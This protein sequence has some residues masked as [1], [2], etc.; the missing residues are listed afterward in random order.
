MAR[1]GHYIPAHFYNDAIP[2]FLRDKTRMTALLITRDGIDRCSGGDLPTGRDGLEVHIQAGSL[3]YPDGIVDRLRQE[4][5]DAFVV[6]FADEDDLDEAATLLRRLRQELPEA[7]LALMV[8][9]A[10]TF[11]AAKQLRKVLDGVRDL[12]LVITGF[13]GGR[14]PMRKVLEHVLWSWPH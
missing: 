3:A 5:M 2:E 7:T 9:E 11:L 8:D 12:S 10:S 6:V 4:Q 13:V 14:V 1:F